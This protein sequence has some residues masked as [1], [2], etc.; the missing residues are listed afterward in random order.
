[1]FLGDSKCFPVWETRSSGLLEV[2]F[3][4]LWISICTSLGAHLW[5]YKNCLFPST[6]VSRN[7][8]CPLVLEQRLLQALQATRGKDIHKKSFADFFTPQNLFFLQ[9]RRVEEKVNLSGNPEPCSWCFPCLS[10]APWPPLA[11]QP[12]ASAVFSSTHTHTDRMEEV[13]WQVFPVLRI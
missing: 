11:P 13:I 4:P 9:S 1:M 5:G 8:A 7:A 10:P 3:N 12:H 6:S 2:Y